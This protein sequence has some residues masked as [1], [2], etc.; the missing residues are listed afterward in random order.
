MSLLRDIQSDLAKQ[1]GDITNVL[2]KC[3]ILASRLRSK[4]FANWVDWELSGYPD[5]QPTPD[6]RK[7]GW[8]CYVNF[9]NR[10]WRYSKLPVPLFVVPEQFR[11]GFQRH[12]FR[13]GIAKIG[14]FIDNGCHIDRPE[15]A[16]LIEGKMCPGMSCQAV[17]ME[18]SG[19]E[20]AQLISA[21]K[22]RI[23]DFVLQIE[24]EN[25][26]AG[27]APA[28]TQ[29]VPNEKLQ[30]L[31]NNFFG[32]VGN[33]AQNAQH[34]SQSANSGIQ[35]QELIKFVAELTEHLHELNLDERQKQRA[36]A[37][38]M[39]IKTELNAEPDSVIVAQAG[40]TL[41]SITEGAIGSLLA[42]AAQPT[43]W[44][45]IHQTMVKLFGP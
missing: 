6:Y 13:D 15:L 21:I 35:T 14:P 4:E 44:H 1:G 3:K 32:A 42:T 10:V 5:S 8:N 36:E 18:I 34:F 30:P 24:L 29:P 2:R 20:F 7:L 41:R 31:V 19:A 45:G 17:W 28:N 26:D 38:I 25:P 40:R 11:D 37:Q 9:M 23:L 22:N 16:A 27:E 12:E 39:T 33:V 43:V